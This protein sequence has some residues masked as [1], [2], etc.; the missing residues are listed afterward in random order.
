M[1]LQEIKSDVSSLSTTII[2]HSSSFMELEEKMSQLM[3][4]CMRIPIKKLLP[5]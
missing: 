2:S 5:M 3:L 1:I 4:L